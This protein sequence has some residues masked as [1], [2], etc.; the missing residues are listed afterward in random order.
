MPQSARF[1]SLSNGAT[2]IHDITLSKSSTGVPAVQFHIE[3]AHEKSLVYLFPE[4][5][6]QPDFPLTTHENLPAGTWVSTKKTIGVFSPG[7]VKEIQRLIAQTPEFQF[8][9]T[10]HEVHDYDFHDQ[11]FIYGKNSVS[12]AGPFLELKVATPHKRLTLQ[13]PI[14]NGSFWGIEIP[15]AELIP[16]N[17]SLQ[18]F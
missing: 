2:H 6:P 18:V 12:Q 11:I 14:L 3:N 17:F 8:W 4:A 10:A 15:E 9:L 16:E 13:I 7:S 5:E 1:L